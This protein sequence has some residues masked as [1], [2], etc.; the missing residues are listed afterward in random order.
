LCKPCDDR[1]KCTFCGETDL[2]PRH[3][4]KKKIA[5]MG[6]VCEGCGRVATE[7]D[8]LCKPRGIPS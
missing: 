3:V 8:L 5:A 7:A 4:C 1:Q 2:G 6:F